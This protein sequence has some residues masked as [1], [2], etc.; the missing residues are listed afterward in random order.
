N[1][2]DVAIDVVGFYA[3]TNPSIGNLTLISPFRTVDTRASDGGGAI[4]HTGVDENGNAIPVQP[5]P[6]GG[7]RRYRLS[8]SGA[9]VPADATGV[10]LNVTIVSPPGGPTGGYVTVFPGG[11]PSAPLASTLNPV[12]PIAFNS[13]EVK[14][15]ANATIGVFSTNDL[16]V[17]IDVVGYLAPAA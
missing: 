2:L 12:T 6:G 5:I 9:P 8:F 16:D 7:T 17:A 15:G 4:V 11:D 14:T 3:P 10:L 1:T 13:W